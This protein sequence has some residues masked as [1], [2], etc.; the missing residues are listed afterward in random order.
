[1]VLQPKQNYDRQFQCFN[2][3][4]W[5]K[6]KSSMIRHIQYECGKEKSFSCEKCGKMFKRNDHLKQHRLTHTMYDYY[7]NVSPNSFVCYQ[8][9]HYYK[10]KSSL[11]R[12]IQYE[13]GKDKSISCELCDKKFKRKDQLKQHMTTHYMCST[14]TYQ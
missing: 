7:I 14:Q 8:C 1:M 10:F 3:G 9:G 13:C 5:Y 11:M 6:A 2:C 12:H 4:N